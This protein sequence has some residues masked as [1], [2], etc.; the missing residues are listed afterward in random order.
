MLDTNRNP[1]ADRKTVE[2]ILKETLGAARVLWLDHG[3]LAGDDTDGHVDMLARFC[4]PSTIAHVI[5]DDKADEHY[6]NIRRMMEQLQGFHRD[7]GRAY[8]LI[9]LPLP[10]PIYGKDNQRLPATYANFLILNGAII[11]PCY[12]VD[13]DRVACD[14]LSLGLPAYPLVKID[15]RP[16]I[17]QGGAIHCATMQLAPGTLSRAAALR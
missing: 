9:A 8:T 5:C 14:I 7:N 10:E 1:S 2:S 4:T 16:F 11:V 13:S 6:A 15:A 3:H 17:A 12:G